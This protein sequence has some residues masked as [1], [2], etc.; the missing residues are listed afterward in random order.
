VAK[1]AKGGQ[2]TLVGQDRAR[3]QSKETLLMFLKKQLQGN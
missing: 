2:V 1:N 3:A